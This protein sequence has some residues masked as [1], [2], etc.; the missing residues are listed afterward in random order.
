LWNVPNWLNRSAYVKIYGNSS[1]TVWFTENITSGDTP[2]PVQFTG[3]SGGD[4]L[5]N[6]WIWIFGDGNVSYSQNPLYSYETVGDYTVT[7]F[8]VNY[9]LG[10]AVF[11]KPTLIN[12]TTHIYP[13]PTPV[14][15]F[16][17][18]TFDSIFDLIRMVLMIGMLLF[19]LAGIAMLILSYLSSGD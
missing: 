2:L 16:N 7:M 5:I 15:P 6:S 8:G 4:I 10:Y 3:Y 18:V 13:V 11:T 9:S 19:V 12:T 14:N 17:A 1:P